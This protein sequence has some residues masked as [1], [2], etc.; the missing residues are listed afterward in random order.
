MGDWRQER[1]GWKV[2]LTKTARV[3]RLSKLIADVTELAEGLPDGCAEQTLLRGM[4]IPL[5]EMLKA[6]L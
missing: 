3:Q 6:E 2:Y 1:K 5:A 4:A